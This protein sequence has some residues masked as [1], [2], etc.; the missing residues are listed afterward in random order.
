MTA[1][2]V[3]DAEYRPLRVVTW[4]TAIA[5]FFLGKTET[6][7]YSHDRTIRGVTREFPM[8]SVVRVLKH[9]KRDKIRV[10]FSRLNV[11]VRDRF[12]CQYC[13]TRCKAE[14]LNFDHVQPRSRG[15]QTSWENIVTCCIGCNDAKGNRTPAEAGMKLMRK[16]VKPTHLPLVTV[17]MRGDVPAEWKPYWTGELEP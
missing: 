8:P 11:Y 2:L 4:Q 7:E 10:K 6:I 9:F 15:G 5:D 16:P 13:G 3:L 1:V 12:T 14:D 17:Q